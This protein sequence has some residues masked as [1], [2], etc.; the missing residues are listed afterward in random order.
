VLSRASFLPSSYLILML[1][2]GGP[3]FFFHS[4]FMD[5]RQKDSQETFYFWRAA[6][7][8]SDAD[9]A[10][11]AQRRRRCASGLSGVK[12]RDPS[13]NLRDPSSA[14]CDQGDC[15]RLCELEWTC[16]RVSPVNLV[17]LETGFSVPALVRRFRP[18]DEQKPEKEDC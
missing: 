12:R 7:S 13:G 9:E 15:L 6:R 8:R 10:I 11:R 1:S 14:L 5:S 17:C 2:P 4:C 3:L 16:L 18:F